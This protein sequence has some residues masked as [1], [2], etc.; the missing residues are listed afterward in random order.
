MRKKCEIKRQHLV[1]VDSKSYV[2]LCHTNPR[3]DGFAGVCSRILLCNCLQLK[4]VTIAEHLLNKMNENSL[5]RSVVIPRH[6]S[7]EVTPDIGFTQEFTINHM[8]VYTY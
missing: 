1:T 7:T 2:S 3:H 4:G 8:S 5:I 6:F